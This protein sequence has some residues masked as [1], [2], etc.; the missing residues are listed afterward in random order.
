MA[1]P[2]V[3]HRFVVLPLLQSAE[4]KEDRS[5]HLTLD[6]SQKKAKQEAEQLMT[7]EAQYHEPEQLVLHVR[8]HEFRRPSKRTRLLRTC[9]VNDP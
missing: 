4:R 6:G 1:V 7:I 5:T 9:T 2:P 3:T 8:T